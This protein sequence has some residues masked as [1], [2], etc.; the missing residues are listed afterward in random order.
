MSI[1]QTVYFGV[2]KYCGEVFRATKAPTVLL[3]FSLVGAPL[4]FSCGM[5]TYAY[6]THST[7]PFRI[8]AVGLN[9]TPRCYR[10]CRKE[11]H[12]AIL[13]FRT[14]RIERDYTSTKSI[15]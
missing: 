12:T 10:R 13:A 4:L 8:F 15:R 3:L 2:P 6:R 7:L 9:R 14:R 11:T 1:I 5:V